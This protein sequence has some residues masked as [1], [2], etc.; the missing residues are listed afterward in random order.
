MLTMQT[1]ELIITLMTLFLAYATAVTLAGAFRAWVAQKMGDDTAASLGF[2]SLNPLSHIDL[3][4]L[5]FLFLFFFGWGRYVPIN[6]LNMDEPYRRFKIVASYF[7]DTAVY[8]FSAFIG[9]TAL[10][11]TGGSRMLFITQ[12]MLRYRQIS[13]S[14]LVTNFPMFS[15]L[16][17]TLSFIVIAFVYLNVVLG[18]LTF[19]LNGFSV[20]LFLV[21]NRSRG[22]QELNY[23]LIILVPIVLIFL[24][25]E[26]LRILAVE[27]IAAAGFGISRAVGLV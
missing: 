5:V 16:A 15:S 26:P 20:G 27:L 17:L 1:T 3:I 23:Y 25:S 14:F 10:V 9:I 21:M 8:F 12:Q 7:S 19:I 18:V 24:F 4:G 11:I 22:Y 13:H 6:H 2:C